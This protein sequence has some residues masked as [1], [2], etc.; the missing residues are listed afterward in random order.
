MRGPQ[1]TPVG[2]V[3]VALAIAIVLTVWVN[4]DFAWLAV[5][6]GALFLVAVVDF[7]QTRHSVRRNYPLFGRLR[8]V[9]EQFRP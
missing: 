9:S 7:F 6:V 2:I 8:W 1:F 5:I 3:G 4:G